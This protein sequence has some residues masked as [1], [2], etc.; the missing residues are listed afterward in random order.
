MSE[1]S[2]SKET[3]VPIPPVGHRR[4][5]LHVMIGP[6]GK[7]SYVWWSRGKWV[8]W[9]GHE[10]NNRQSP[11]AAAKFGWSYVR[12]AIEGERNIDAC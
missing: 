2:M 3:S 11:D 6:H 10:R 7:R 8:F 9:I 1:A 5:S 12:P 4:P